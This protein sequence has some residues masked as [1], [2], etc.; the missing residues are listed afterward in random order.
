[1]PRP[2]ISGE[3]GITSL[4][5][6]KTYYTSNAGTIDLRRAIADYLERRFSLTYSPER[7]IVVTVGGSEAI[8]LTLRALIEPGDEVIIPTPCFVCYGPLVEMCHGCAGLYRN[9]SGGQ[10]QADGR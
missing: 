8:D 10:F 6:G 2:G 4:E 9:Q 5:Q 7:E 3:A 1:M